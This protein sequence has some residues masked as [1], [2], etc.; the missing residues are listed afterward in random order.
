[1]EDTNWAILLSDW[2]IYLPF[3]ISFF[4]WGVFIFLRVVPSFFY[5]QL[6]YKDVSGLHIDDPKRVTNR[7]VTAIITAYEPPKRFYDTIRSVVSNQPY[8]VLIA[9]DS[10]CMKNDPRFIEKC[11]AC[12]V[13]GVTNVRVVEVTQKGKRA[14]L[15]AGIKETNSK[16]VALVDDDIEWK[17]KSKKYTFLQKLVAPFQ[18]DDK[19]GGV[20]CKQVARIAHFFDVWRILAD[21]RLAVRFLELMATTTMDRGASCISGRTGLYRIYI[22]KKEEFYEYLG[23]ETLWGMKLLSGDDKCLTRYVVNEGYDTY[24]QLRKTCKLATSFGNG[25]EFINQMLRWSRNT[26]RSDIKSLFIERKIWKRHPLTAIIMFDKMLSPFFI[27]G[28]LIFIVVTIFMGLDFELFIPW[29]I[30]LVATRILKLSYYLVEHPQYIVYI[31]VF[32][33]YQ[34]FQAVIKIIALFTMNQRGWLTRSVKVKGNVIVGDEKKDEP[35]NDIEQGTVNPDLQPGNHFESEIIR[36]DSM[37]SD[38]IR[39]DSMESEMIRSDSMESLMIDE[40]EIVE[41]EMKTDVNKTDVNKT[42]ENKMDEKKSKEKEKKPKEKKSKEKKPKENKEQ[43]KEKKSK[44]KEK[45]SKEKKMEVT[46]E[47]PRSESLQ[48]IT[49]V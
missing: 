25:T 29:L 1:M 9:A 30:W 15:I 10:K 35:K 5:K 3:Y 14:A 20:G 12:S 38:M 17:S 6:K 46:N 43:K 48:S 34:Y 36:S 27:V 44:E 28:G 8:E 4:R 39:S 22:V 32:V 7:D 21:M 19:I 23:N 18:H 47:L 33:V 37:E 24:H 11:E 49:I 42:D 40:S 13:E 45:K 26:W 41:Y 31:P 2:Q 16:L